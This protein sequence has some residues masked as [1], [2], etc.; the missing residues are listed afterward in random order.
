MC[1]YEPANEALVVSE[2]VECEYFEQMIIE[3][4]PSGAGQGYGLCTYNK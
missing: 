2:V 1:N 4:A 3:F